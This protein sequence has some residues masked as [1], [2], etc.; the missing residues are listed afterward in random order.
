MADVL[1][2]ENVLDG[3][4]LIPGSRIG[5]RG[6]VRRSD[7]SAQVLRNSRLEFR[8]PPPRNY[9]GGEYYRCGCVRRP[10]PARSCALQYPAATNRRVTAVLDG[11]ESACRF[12]RAGACRCRGSSG[13][14][15][16]RHIHPCASTR[17]FDTDGTDFPKYP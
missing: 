17:G 15:C 12:R 3:T 14:I 2:Q 11:R 13:T 5:Q 4:K 8:L 9:R 16:S 7:S 6:C 1:Y 10:S